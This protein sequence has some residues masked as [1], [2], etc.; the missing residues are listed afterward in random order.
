M[1]PIIQAMKERRSVRTYRPDPVPRGLLDQVLEAGLYAPSGM[2][3]QRVI[4]VAI[5]DRA[6]RDR[7]AAVNRQ[8]GGWK[9]PSFDPFYGAPAVL[10]V[11]AERDSFTN[12]YDGSLVMAN[13]ML[14]AHALGLGSCWIHR[15]RE[16]FELP[17]F[18]AL[19]KDL[20]ITGD[21]IGVGHCILGW[22][23][24]PLP[25]AAPRKEGRIVYAGG[26]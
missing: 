11:L 20:G 4:T 10:I 24:G 5:T 25:E 19:L 13:L 8:I 21:Y 2:G 9:D 26:E 7:L 6:L 17:E 15:A 23:A 14:A 1:N 12:V 16:E 18:Q 22:P 3:T